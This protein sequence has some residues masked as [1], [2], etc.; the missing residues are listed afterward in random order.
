MSLR[1]VNFSVVIELGASTAANK[2]AS[3][4]DFSTDK[5]MLVSPRAHLMPLG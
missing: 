4:K 1:S 2:A 3:L 5:P